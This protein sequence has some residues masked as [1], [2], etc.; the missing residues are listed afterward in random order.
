MKF[1]REI[2]SE[3]LFEELRPLL[4][5]HW[6]EIAHYQDIELKPDW[7]TYLKVEE[8]GCLRVFTA[9]DDQEKLIGYA[10]FM[11]RP[12]LHYSDS[13]QACQ[14]ILYVDKERR[15][16]GA[17]FIAWCDRALQAEGVQA[18]Y[19]HVKREHNFGSLLERM[20]YQ[21]VDLIYSKR[22]D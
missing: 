17:K 19:H 3:S 14:D 9:R 13:I 8:M 11:V 4:F 22:L 1:K 16:F 5:A 20:G 21:L 6:R 15:G 12:N 7:S 2:A 18:V 10:V